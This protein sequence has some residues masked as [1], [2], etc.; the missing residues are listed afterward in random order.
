MV[1]RFGRNPTEIC[2]IFN[3]LLDLVYEQHHH[4]LESWDQPFLSSEMLQSYA[5]ATYNKGTVPHWKT[6]LDL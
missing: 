5:D 2:L 1:G 4:R 3:Q 6:A